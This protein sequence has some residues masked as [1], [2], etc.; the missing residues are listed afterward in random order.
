MKGDLVD[1]DL[2][3]NITDVSVRELDVQTNGFDG[4]KS[5][6]TSCGLLALF[7]LSK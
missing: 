7:H 2:N 3:V 4:K 6:H 5:L 1:L